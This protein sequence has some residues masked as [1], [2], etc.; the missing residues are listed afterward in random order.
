MYKLMLYFFYGSAFASHNPA[1]AMA[2]GLP[3]HFDVKNIYQIRT[4]KQNAVA[5]RLLPATLLE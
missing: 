2:A 4:E 5:R 3:L 1:R